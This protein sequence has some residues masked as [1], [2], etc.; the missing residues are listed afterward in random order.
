MIHHWKTV[1]E[2]KQSWNLEEE[3]NAEAMERAASWLTS[4]GLLS[5]LSYR[6]PGPPATGMAP[7]T[8]I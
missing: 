7:S 5:L 3:A 2:L 6:N 4:H 1:Q 8:L